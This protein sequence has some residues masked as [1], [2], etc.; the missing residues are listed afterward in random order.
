M[1]V[2][3][4]ETVKKQTSYQLLQSCYQV[5]SKDHRLAAKACR[6]HQLLGLSS[7]VSSVYRGSEYN[8]YPRLNSTRQSPLDSSGYPYFYR[9]HCCLEEVVSSISTSNEHSRYRQDYYRQILC[10]YRGSV[11]E[12]A[13]RLFKVKESECMLPSIYQSAKLVVPLSLYKN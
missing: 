4:R 5:I 6:I 7:A 2:C 9:T 3:S 10:R 1:E 13:W 11:F 12:T 8:R